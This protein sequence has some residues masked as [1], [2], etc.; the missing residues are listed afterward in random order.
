M[1][2]SVTEIEIPG[3]RKVVAEQEAP[4]VSV[5]LLTAAEIREEVRFFRR[6]QQLAIGED[7]IEALLEIQRECQLAADRGR[8][9]FLV[10]IEDFDWAA[11][12]TDPIDPIS[13]GLFVGA[14]V[15]LV[16]TLSKGRKL[17]EDGEL[18]FDGITATADTRGRFG[19]LAPHA[20]TASHMIQLNALVRAKFDS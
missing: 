3:A 5:R 7:Q 19:Q 13:N 17:V 6:S 1:R 15:S 8:N 14:G 16:F 2:T 12:S 18:T 4:E 11:I 20:A 9:S 10:G